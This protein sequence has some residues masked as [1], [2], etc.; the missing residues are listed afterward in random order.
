[1]AA[2]ADLGEGSRR[3]V[4]RDLVALADSDAALRPLTP[5]PTVRS[6]RVPGRQLTTAAGSCISSLCL[7]A[8][9]C[10]DQHKVWF[11]SVSV[12][13]F[14]LAQRCSWERDRVVF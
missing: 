7:C 4:P 13:D 11:G 12:V 1:M 10:M 3:V 2:I 6:T 9:G 8:L 5:A 14:E